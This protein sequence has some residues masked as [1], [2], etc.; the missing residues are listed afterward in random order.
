MNKLNVLVLL[1][2]ALALSSS[3]SFADEHA[4]HH[5]GA[6]S[7]MHS[8]SIQKNLGDQASAIKMVNGKGTINKVMVEHHTVNISHQPI[9]ELGWPKMKMNF[10][11][12]EDVDLSM[13]KMGQSV[14]FTLELDPQQN[15]IITALKVVD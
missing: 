5:T 12:A 15:T 10:K 14:E 8:Q 6:H 2:S 11:T 13:L 7:A 4:N 3:H 1:S 9:A